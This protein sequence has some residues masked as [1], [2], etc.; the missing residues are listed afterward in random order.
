MPVDKEKNV[1]NYRFKYKVKKTSE[2]GILT[3]F[4]YYKQVYQQNEAKRIKY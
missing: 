4:T 2:K 3:G 1:I